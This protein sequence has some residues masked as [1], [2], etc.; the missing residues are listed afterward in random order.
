MRGGDP[1]DRSRPSGDDE[2]PSVDESLIAEMMSLTVRERLR[3][4]D[5][6]V[7]TVN[8]LRTAFAKHVRDA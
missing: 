2:P 7:R 3:Q 5:R 6:M 1:E 4:N 8:A